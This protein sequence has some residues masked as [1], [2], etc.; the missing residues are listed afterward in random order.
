MKNST[1]LCLFG[2]EGRSYYMCVIRY[3]KAFKLTHKVPFVE[4]LQA[5]I[6][7]SLFSFSSLLLHL[8]NLHIN[9]EPATYNSALFISSEPQLFH[10]AHLSEK[11]YSDSSRSSGKGRYSINL[12]WSYGCVTEHALWKGPGIYCLS[13]FFS[14]GFI[15][16]VLSVCVMQM[17]NSEVQLCR[18]S[19]AWET[20]SKP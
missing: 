1:S 9:P 7:V 6:S 13:L 14:P 10:Y 3:W 5:I 20:L 15:A 19:G 11:I 12:S 18:P 16:A 17:S 2:V 4:K 8:N